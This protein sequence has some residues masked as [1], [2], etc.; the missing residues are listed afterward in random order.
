MAEKDA[1]LQA[2]GGGATGPAGVAEGF[3]KEAVSH[4]S[5]AGHQGPGISI[6]LIWGQGPGISISLFFFSS[7][8]S[9][10]FFFLFPYCFVLFCFFVFITSTFQLIAHSTV[11]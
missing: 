3:G 6:F 1:V 11:Y 7:L 8:F 10:L 9:F 2:A 4:G 5:G